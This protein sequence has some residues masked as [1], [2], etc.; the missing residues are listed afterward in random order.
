LEA[1]DLGTLTRRFANALDGFVDIGG[2]VARSG[3]LDQ[4]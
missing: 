3:H 4:G 1:D 2:D